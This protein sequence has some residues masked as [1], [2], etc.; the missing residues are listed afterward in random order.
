ME[1][2]EDKFC[3]PSSTDSDKTR[4]S[5][6]S[7]EPIVHT[8]FRL[9]D[10]TAGIEQTARAIPLRPQT[11]G[12]VTWE[13]NAVRVLR[14]FF[15]GN[16]E[17]PG[18]EEAVDGRYLP[19]FLSPYRD[20]P[21]LRHDYPLFLASSIDTVQ[22]D[23]QSTLNALPITQDRNNGVFPLPG[24][25]DDRM[26]S[27]AEKPKQL[28]KENLARLEKHIV[29]I[30]AD[31][32]ASGDRAPRDADTV[33]EQAIQT[34]LSSVHLGDQR[35]E[36]LETGL[37]QLKE[38]MPA[39][40][41]LP[42]S[43]RAPLHMLAHMAKRRFRLQHARILMQVGN[44]VGELNALL[45]MEKSKSIES[46]EPR[47]VQD[48]IGPGGNRF[49]DP[50]ALSNLMDHS[51]GSKVMS[52]ARR[53]RIQETL[54]ILENEQI[55]NSRSPQL[56]LVHGAT[57][58]GA[59][60]LAD[61]HLS[62]DL[63]GEWTLR[64]SSNP[65]PT[66]RV[67][68]DEQVKWLIRVARAMRIATIELENT[69]DP[70]VHDAWFSGFDWRAL[71]ESESKLAP[72]VLVID[73]A[74]N[75]ARNELVGLSRLLHA[76][77]PI[78]VI[79]E[80]QPGVDPGAENEEPAALDSF[81]AYRTELGYLGVSHRQAVVTQSSA[82][83]HQ[84]LLAGFDMALR[85]RRPALHLLGACYPGNA[86]QSLPPWPWL[87]ESAAVES[88]A[89]PL[90]QYDPTFGGKWSVPLSLADNPQPEIDW[91]GYPFQYRT[92][93]GAV[94]DMT[95]TFG[96][97]DYAL[98]DPHWW[99]HFYPVPDILDAREIIHLD[100]Y[101]ALEPEHRGNRLPFVWA[102]HDDQ[103]TRGGQLRR[104]IV[105]ATLVEAC[106]DRRE[107]WRT[108]QALAGVRN[109]HVESAVAKV[110]ARAEE[111]IEAQRVLLVTEHRIALEKARKE[112]GA[113]ALR[114][115]TQTLLGM[116]FTSVSGPS[117]DDD[118][119]VGT[120]PSQASSPT[121]LPAV[122]HV[123]T[124]GQKGEHQRAH[125]TEESEIDAGA[126]GADTEPWIDT[127]LCTSCNECIE[128]NPRLFVYDDNKQAE[129]GDLAA[130]T[131]DEW[132]A[133]AEVCPAQCI[134]PGH[135]HQV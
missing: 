114:R 29:E 39:G 134:H 23:I 38:E 40:H 44:L 66:A 11:A 16:P 65:F 91:P 94:T 12:K 78:Q 117:H 104:L 24:L 97:A 76:D 116:D 135:P 4:S 28:L 57:V 106:L 86:E 98:L 41:F 92:E 19:A 47:M 7:N 95:M 111:N 6:L 53:Q 18:P 48:S 88:R 59:Y 69:Y 100:D 132:V 77:R 10:Q 58:R 33:L 72:V 101:L 62:S 93:D 73:S 107:F 127:P 84:H 87:F 83:R 52:P 130:G 5:E 64:E 51:H 96:F 103:R 115:L 79:L 131:H 118:R 123:P 13:D 119:E 128:L 105:S 108:L 129:I 74:S 112:A 27:F 46:I 22:M 42:F 2:A 26:G 81:T 85:T 89:H 45:E 126:L 20:G 70:K 110:E 124:A 1:N 121:P 50:L 36:Q 54:E 34:L 75:V 30:V 71:S 68:F 90:F 3:M 9:G 133:A 113:D 102:V 80:T 8:A 32:N 61:D 15:L 49:L 67:V 122:A 17:V 35:R 125:E 14:G 99:R 56:T 63:S 25:F 109:R 21:V 43:R 120:L 55:T 31:S 60:G 82:T 37:F